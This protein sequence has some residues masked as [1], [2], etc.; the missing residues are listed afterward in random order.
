VRRKYSLSQDLRC[1]AIALATGG[2]AHM[3]EK[4]DLRSAFPVEP[5]PA[6]S[7]LVV[8]FQGDADRGALY[9]ALSGK[10]WTSITYEYLR[11]KYSAP[12]SES[13]A[14]LTGEGKAYF[15]PAYIRICESKPREADDVPHA[16]LFYVCERNVRAQRFISLLTNRQ[17]SILMTFLET[18]F[19]SSTTHASQLETVRSI[20]TTP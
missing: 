3:N 1:I 6:D 19:A 16:I 8:A 11:H 9:S 5:R 7:H 2:C 15:L 13:F 17:R 18:H 12:L 10:I 4:L 20:L 14:C